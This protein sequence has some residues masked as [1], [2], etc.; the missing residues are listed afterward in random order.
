[1]NTRKGSGWKSVVEAK[2]IGKSGCGFTTGKIY[3][4]RTSISKVSKFGV[5][6]EGTYLCIYDTESSAM[7]PYSRLETFL[8]NWEIL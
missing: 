2:F 5:P 7:C 8:E 6:L 1:M 3:K 4:I